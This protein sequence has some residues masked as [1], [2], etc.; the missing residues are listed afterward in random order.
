MDFESIKTIEDLENVS[1]DAI[2][3]NFERLVGFIFEENN[4]HVKINTIKSFNRKRRQYD[5]T[6]RKNGHVFL[7]ECKRW[8]G[9]R[10]RLSALKSAVKKHIERAD[11]YNDVTKEH[12]IP[13]IVTLIEE[14]IKLYE[15][16]PIVPIFKL[17][18]FIGEID[19]DI[20]YG[21]MVDEQSYL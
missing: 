2:W 21:S 19:R 7:A 8:S 4:F 14:D 15:D 18:S 13:I 11:F 5:V 20:N 1:R 3:Q 12:V 17:N 10:Y 9:N 6:A 16:V